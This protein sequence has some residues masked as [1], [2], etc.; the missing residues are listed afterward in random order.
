MAEKLAPT[1]ANYEM[2]LH[3]VLDDNDALRAQLADTKKRLDA[4]MTAF[5]ERGSLG[6][7]QE[8]AN[9]KRL[10]PETRIRAAG[11]AV[12]FE[13]P[14]LQVTATATVPLYDLLQER[15]R[16]GKVIEHAPRPDPKPAA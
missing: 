3:K 14:K 7:L 11:L 2:A 4:I 13:R 15:R 8:L 1:I 16:Q 6:I 12:P 9:D 10:P 5:N